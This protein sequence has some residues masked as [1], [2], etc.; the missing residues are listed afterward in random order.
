MGIDNLDWKRSGSVDVHVAEERV[1]SNNEPAGGRKGRKLRTEEV[2]VRGERSHNRDFDG[3]FRR[4]NFS[5][6]RFRPQL[7]GKE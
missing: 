4:C 5:I 1:V 6:F 7:V 3:D 2:E